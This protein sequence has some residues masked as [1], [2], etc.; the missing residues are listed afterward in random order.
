MDTLVDS[1]MTRV[2]VLGVPVGPDGLSALSAGLK[3]ILNSREKII[4]ILE[5]VTQS[6]N[7]DDIQGEL[8]DLQVELVNHIK[9]HISSMEDPLMSIINALG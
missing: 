6:T 3:D 4:R 8:V 5:Q 1:F 9:P 2:E 7:R